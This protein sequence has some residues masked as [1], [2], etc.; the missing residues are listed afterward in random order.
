MKGIKGKVVVKDIDLKGGEE[1]DVY[2]IWKQEIEMMKCVVS[3][4]IYHCFLPHLN[5]FQLY[6]MSIY[7]ECVWIFLFQ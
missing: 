4:S 6:E 7:C 2:K 5:L 3:S 1:K